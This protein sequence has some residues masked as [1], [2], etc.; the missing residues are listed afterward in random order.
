[1]FWNMLTVHCIINTYACGNI[2]DIAIYMW[3]KHTVLFG[4]LFR[5]YISFYWLWLTPRQHLNHAD[6]AAFF[7]LRLSIPSTQYN[8]FGAQAKNVFNLFVQFCLFAHTYYTHITYSFV[9]WQPFAD[10]FPSLSQFFLVT[11]LAKVLSKRLC[12]KQF[13]F[14]RDTIIA[15]SVDNHWII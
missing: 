15:N 5:L 10:F 4:V 7:A 8:I 6:V 11:L 3:N 1:M 2:A 14:S 12:K 9:L 13:L